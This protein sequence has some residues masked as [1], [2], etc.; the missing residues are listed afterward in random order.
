MAAGGGGQE[1][2]PA[3]YNTQTTLGLEVALRARYKPGAARF[4]LTS[5]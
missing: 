1:L 3:R 2:I 4:V 5:D